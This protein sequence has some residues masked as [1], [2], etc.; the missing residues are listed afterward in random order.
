MLAILLALASAAGYRELPAGAGSLAAGRAG[1][2]RTA[3][4]ARVW[5]RPDD[6]ILPLAGHRSPSSA[7]RLGAHQTGRGDRRFELYAGFRD[8][9]IQRGGA[10]G[11]RDR[12]GGI[13]GTCRSPA[14]RT[15]RHAGHDRSESGSRSTMVGVSASPAGPG[16]AGAGHPAAGVIW[17]L[18]AGASFAVL[19][20]A[21]NRAGTGSGLSPAVATQ[22]TALVAVTCLGALT[23]EA[24]LPPRRATGPAA[25]TGADRRRGRGAVLLCRPGRPARRDSGPHLAVPGSDHRARP[26]VPGRAAHRDQADRALPRCRLRRSSS[27][28]PGHGSGKECRRRCRSVPGGRL[29][30]SP[31]LP[32]LAEAG[33]RRV[34]SGQMNRNAAAASITAAVAAC[35]P[36]A[37]AFGPLRRSTMMA[38]PTGMMACRQHEPAQ[39][40][41]FPGGEQDEDDESRGDVAHAFDGKVR[42]GATAVL[43]DG[44]PDA[45][46][47]SPGRKEKSRAYEDDAQAEQSGQPVTDVRENHGCSL[48]FPHP[49]A[50]SHGRVHARCR[51]RS[52]GCGAGGIGRPPKASRTR[53]RAATRSPPGWA[54]VEKGVVAGL[55]LEQAVRRLLA[56]G[57]PGQVVTGSYVG[58]GTATSPCSPRR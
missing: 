35:T 55:D 4:L 34:G 33:G 14:R 54:I 15:A 46:R 45:G 6:P 5:R 39:Q 12:L 19:F 1:V 13:L 29:N 9:Q 48:P 22:V 10:A 37:V 20:I 24:R 36:Y 31:G 42:I 3:I 50:A 16:R 7:A 17:G 21:L 40:A 58:H 26:R 11:A 23:G 56:G 2:I 52:A 57:D 38:S 43:P 8:A 32:E 51:E 28:Q 18:L 44:D 49:R 25:L 30:R 27:P 53:R 41:R 47:G